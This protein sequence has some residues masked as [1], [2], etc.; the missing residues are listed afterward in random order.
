MEAFTVFEAFAA[1]SAAIAAPLLLG[2]IVASLGHAL[3]LFAMYVT[4]K[5]S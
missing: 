1:S 3:R 5:S 2:I 4:S